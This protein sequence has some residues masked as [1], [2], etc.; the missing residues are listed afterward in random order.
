[1]TDPRIY[2]HLGHLPRVPHEEGCKLCAACRKWRPLPEF[3]GDK[4]RWDGLR[5]EC[6][7]CHSEKRKQ[8]SRERGIRPQI[9]RRGKYNDAGLKLCGKCAQ[10]K[11]PTDFPSDKS[12][13]DGRASKCKACG[14]T[15][16][17]NQ[18]VS[19]GAEIRSHMRSY[20]NAKF[21]SDIQY[22]LR[23]V[24]KNRIWWALR[25]VA[26]KSAKTETLIGCTMLELKTHLE[27]QFTE[28]MSW[29]NYGKWHIDHIIP[30]AAFDLT[31]PVQQRQCFHYS[32]LQPLWAADNFSKGKKNDPNR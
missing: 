17:K 14:A 18:L 4:Q 21:A 25:G 31:D 29:D 30:C 7:T 1:M 19:R 15:Y 13:W 20:R 6:G 12:H 3:S 16:K 9:E 27:R 10:W 2:A 28:G 8:R 26:D 24:C 32:N 22:R 11:A 23:M 5:V